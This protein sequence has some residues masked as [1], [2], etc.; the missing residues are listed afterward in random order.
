MEL[1]YYLFAVPPPKKLIDDVDFYKPRTYEFNFRVHN[2]KMA[3]KQMT[4]YPPMRV[5]HTK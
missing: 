3:G 4:R 5:A 1:I 2:I